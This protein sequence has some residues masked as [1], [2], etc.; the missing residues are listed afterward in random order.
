MTAPRRSGLPRMRF[1]PVPGL[2]PQTLPSHSYGGGYA[3]PGWLWTLQTPSRGGE[4]RLSV[5][6]FLTRA[7]LSWI[8]PHPYALIK[9]QLP[10]QNPVS[11][12]CLSWCQ[13]SNL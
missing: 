11:K 6:P 1:C 5:A 13:A 12:Y 7:S 3:R 2:E 10:P 9:L 8:S 4:A